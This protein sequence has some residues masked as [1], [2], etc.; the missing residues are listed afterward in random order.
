MKKGENYSEL[1]VSI[2]RANT[3]I[4]SLDANSFVPVTFQWN[5][6]D[7]ERWKKLSGEANERWMLRGEWGEGGERGRKPSWDGIGMLHVQGFTVVILCYG[8]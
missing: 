6:L 7:V 5:Y 3:N 2:P 8:L 1:R 4:S